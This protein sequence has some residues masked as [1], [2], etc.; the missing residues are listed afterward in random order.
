MAV[1]N[2]A[3]GGWRVVR[4]VYML[5]AT[6]WRLCDTLRYVSQLKAVE[7]WNL[8]G[9]RLHKF[10]PEL[11]LFIHGLNLVITQ[12]NYSSWNLR[13]INYPCPCVRCVFVWCSVSRW[14]VKVDPFT[15]VKC[16][17]ILTYS[18]ECGGCECHKICLS[19]SDPETGSPTVTAT[20]AGVASFSF[21]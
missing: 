1:K 7:I 11:L 9:S 21:V 13:N 14:K 20:A 18:Y 10:F 2:W 15:Q 16:H 17:F 6:K 5:R 19:E 8:K 12:K 3:V 4:L